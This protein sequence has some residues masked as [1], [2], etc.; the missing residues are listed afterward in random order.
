MKKGTAWGFALEKQ[1]FSEI[2]SRKLKQEIDCEEI[3]YE[4]KSLIRKGS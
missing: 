4:L 3:V 2:Y 1:C